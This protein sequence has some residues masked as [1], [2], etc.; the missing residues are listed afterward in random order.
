MDAMV[1]FRS[2]DKSL[3][4]NTKNTVVSYFIGYMW[5]KA[6]ITKWTLQ[7]VHLEQFIT[8]KSGNIFAKNYFKC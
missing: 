5:S 6:S 2:A 8:K 4:K 7:I 1:Y 3:F